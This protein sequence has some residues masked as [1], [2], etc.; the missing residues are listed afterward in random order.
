[1]FVSRDFCKIMKYHFFCESPTPLPPWSGGGYSST[2]FASPWWRQGSPFQEMLHWSCSCGKVSPRILGKVFPTCFLW[3]SSL[4]WS[5]FAWF[6]VPWFFNMQR[7]THRLL[8]KTS[9]WDSPS[10]KNH[11]TFR[12]T[13]IV[14]VNRMILLVCLHLFFMRSGVDSPIFVGHKKRKNTTI[15]IPH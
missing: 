11:G 1:M 3:Y 2:S 15:N 4:K 10:W 7:W 8:G 14:G 13:H 12:R 5:S 6:G 9:L